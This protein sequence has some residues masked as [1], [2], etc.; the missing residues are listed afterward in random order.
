MNLQA[1]ATTIENILNQTPDIYRVFY[2]SKNLDS[3]VE[4][5]YS[6]NLPTTKQE[7]IPCIVGDIT[8]L[9]RAIPNT[10]ISD[11]TATLQ[12]VFPLSK[13]ANVEVAF[14]AL[15]SNLVGKTITIGNF[16]CVFNIEKPVFSGVDFAKLTE[17]NSLDENI[18]LDKTQLYGIMEVR[19]YFCECPNASGFEFGNAFDFYISTEGS[20]STKLI[21]LVANQMV[22]RS[23]L[24]EQFINNTTAETFNQINGTGLT[25]TFYLRNRTTSPMSYIY[26]DASEG[27]NQNRVYTITRK[28]GSTTI[29][30]PQSMLM[31]QATI[32]YSLGGI[33]TIT[34]TFQ[35][36]LE[37]LVG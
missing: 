37:G 9:Y 31:T 16:Y 27:G 5:L 3:R 15:V 8:G 2:W 4:Q 23:S 36:A 21:R 14:D 13:K 25:L 28:I 19:I 35:K 29:G 17:L 12:I 6:N 11:C 1:F 10:Q 33:V 26:L 7:F 34:A 22:S 20:I 32:D 24:D 30:N 18:T